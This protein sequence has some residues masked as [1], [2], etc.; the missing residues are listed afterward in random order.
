LGVMSEGNSFWKELTRRRVVR[1]ALVY[2]AVGWAIFEGSD[3]LTSVLDLPGFTPRLVLML[4]VL[5]FPVAVVLAWAF[6][7]TPDGIQ[8]AERYAPPGRFN[9]PFFGG[10][11]VGVL[12]VSGLAFVFFGDGEGDSP[13]DPTLDQ[14][15]V[16]VLPF[17]FNAPQELSYLGSGFMDLLAARLDGAVGPRAIDPG[18]VVSAGRGDDPDALEVGRALGAGSVLTG[19]VVGGPAGIVVTAEYTDVSDGSLRAS[20]EVEG[21]PE[22]LTELADRLIVQLLSLSSGEYTHSIASMTTTSPDALEAYLLGRRAWRAGLYDESVDYYEEALALD[23]TF[24]VAAIACMDQG[25]MGISA[26]CT[27]DVEDLAWRHRDRLTPRDRSYLEAIIPPGPRTRAERMEALER[28]LRAQPDRIEALYRL[29]DLAFHSLGMFPA[30]ERVERTRT[31]WGRALELQRDYAPVLDHLLFTEPRHGTPEQLRSFALG[32]AERGSFSAYLF[33][34]IAEGGTRINLPID[35]IATMPAVG[36]TYLKWLPVYA[37]DQIPDDFIPFVEGIFEE[38]RRRAAAG[39]DI[40]L[41]SALNDEYDLNLV[42]GRPARAAAVREEAIRE[43][44]RSRHTRATILDHA[45]LGASAEDVEAAVEIFDARLRD[46]QGEPLTMELARDLLAVEIWRHQQDRGYSNPAAAERLRAAVSGAPH[47]E[48][49]RFEALALLIEAWARVRDGR[50]APELARLTEIIREDPG[51]P[52]STNDFSMA[53]SRV[54]EEA[55]DLE[56]ALDMMYRTRSGGRYTAK[57]WLERGR[58]SALTGDTSAAILN[59][60]R[61]LKLEVAA[62]PSVLPEVEAVRAELARLGG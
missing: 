49:L 59:Y 38:A 14:D 56:A 34:E 41:S 12:A 36:L 53:V 25:T 27:G 18:T 19:S 45:W 35:S 22:S 2:V 62:E 46:A 28:V 17:R 5:G 55:G 50:P 29:G 15:A 13:V 54:F 10:L 16:A 9:L 6:Q 21:P 4:A 39:L 20:A 40:R 57:L 48:D 52:V 33:E 31:I 7:V 8:K 3:T 44:V 26:S 30:P 23:S 42:Y 1:V 24:A 60:R 32:L 47:P 51:T 61:W 11:A 43:G 37:P 58:L